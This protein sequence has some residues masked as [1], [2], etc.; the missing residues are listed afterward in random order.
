MNQ[1]IN[2]PNIE[3]ANARLLNRADGYYIQ[4]VCYIPKENKIKNE[5]IDKTIGIDFG[6]STS[7]TTSEGEKINVSIQE[8]ER[9]KCLQKKFARQVKGS[10]NWYK[11]LELIKK[12]YQKQTNRKDDISN[13]IVHKFS[14]YKTVVIQD[15][16]LKNWS[17]NHHGKAIQHSVLGRVKSK[18]KTKENVVIL[19]KTVPTTKLC[20]NCG[21]YHDEL[22]VWD[23]TFKC[24]CGVE[25]DRD[26]H[27]SKNMVWFYENN[28]GVE[29]TNIKRVEMEALVLGVIRNSKNQL[30]SKKHEAYS[31]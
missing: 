4:L 19:S 8:S 7:F 11:T 15:E 31:L 21:V 20:T 23:R 10:K 22:K 27:A 6:C 12:E 13:K 28:V 9:L 24:E 26:I 29:R 17:K 18:L 2:I 30:V 25:M 3:Y 16:Q 5:K 14:Q 1:F